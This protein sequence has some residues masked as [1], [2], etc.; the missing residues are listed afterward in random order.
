VNLAGS[1][2]PGGENKGSGVQA[3]TGLKA[4]VVGGLG[5]NAHAT[6]VNLAV[7]APIPTLKQQA[8]TTPIQHSA[9]KVIYKPRPEYTAEARQLHLE[10]TVTVHI[11]VRQDGSVEVVGISDGLGHGLDESARRAV[12]GTKFEP[13][14]DASGHP[15]PWD[16]VVKVAFQLAG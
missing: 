11:H 3:V 2:S 5:S 9:P 15:I 12:E 7:A 16:G 13:A 10:G 14:T 4:G 8:A 6:G 1:G